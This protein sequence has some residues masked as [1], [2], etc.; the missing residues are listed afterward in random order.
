MIQFRLI[1]SRNEFGDEASGVKPFVIDLEA[2]NGTFVNDV[3]IPASRYYELKASDGTCHSFIE[4]SPSRPS[5][6][7]ADV[8]FL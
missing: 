4:S 3:E 5:A 8:L 7:S 6:R 1:K 2:T